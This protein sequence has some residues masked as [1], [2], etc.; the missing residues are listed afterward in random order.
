MTI[1]TEQLRTEPQ[2]REIHRDS[3][4]EPKSVSS[5]AILAEP[6]AAAPCQPIARIASLPRAG[7]WLP[8]VGRTGGPR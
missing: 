3:L 1:I 2:R 7:L 6:P 8:P 5:L 4:A